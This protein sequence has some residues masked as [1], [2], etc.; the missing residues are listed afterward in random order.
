MN[1]KQ[2]AKIRDFNRF[3][4]NFIGLLDK[5]VLDSNYTLPEVRVMFEIN[6]HKEITAKRI[7]EL[8]GM[9]KGY[10]SHMLVKFEKAGLITKKADNAD[11]RMQILSFT[12]EGE[13]VFRTLNKAS[14]NQ[15]RELLTNLAEA[16][17][18]ELIGYMDKIK[19]ILSKKEQMNN[20]DKEIG[21]RSEMKPGDLGYIMYRQSKLYS[22][23]YNYGVSFDTY[24]GESIGEFC[25]QYDPQ[26]DRLWICE[27]DTQIVGSILLM[28]RKEGEA[29]L[30]YF[31]LES[32]CRGLGLG[33]KLLQQVIDFAKERNYHKIYLWTENEL[34][35][36]LHLYRKF[37]FQ[38]AEKKDSTHF[39]KSVVELRLDLVLDSNKA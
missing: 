24:V 25:Q 20:A 32:D 28:H 27:R 29:Q 34:D 8:L 38:F 33:N 5:N 26:L 11:G 19:N 1:K 2:I 3:Y 13:K 21:I 23:E 6:R 22:E 17:T 30:R 39:G 9:D 4:T 15:L 35:T 14:E 16:E 12:E 7:T 31:Y 36:A 18:G 10:L 37:G